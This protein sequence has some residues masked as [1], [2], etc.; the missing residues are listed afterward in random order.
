MTEITAKTPAQIAKE[1][2]QS[3]YSAGSYADDR[4]AWTIQT[5]LRACQGKR[6]LEVG[7]GNGSLLEL[8]RPANQV[9][10]VDA[11]SDGIAACA[12]CGV[13]GHCLDPSSEPLP[14]PDESFD[15][16][17]CL[18]T[19]EHLMNPYYA[20]L[21]MRRVLKCGGRLI[22]SV[23]NPIWGHLLLYPGLFEYRYFRKFR[24]QC[25]FEIARVDHWQWAPRETILPRWLRRSVVLRSRYVAGLLRKLL[26]VAWKAAGR[27]P[28]FCYWLWTFDLV[29]VEKGQSSLLHRQSSQTAPKG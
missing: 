13:E 18:E 3:F 28:Y 22:C 27:F 17:V 19:M 21:E 23:P 7:C 20:L 2:H 29:K 16:V 11:A 4:Y 6:I 5:F 14:F 24:E 8:L 9:V 25:D 15:F 26:E 10:G 12:L 1:V